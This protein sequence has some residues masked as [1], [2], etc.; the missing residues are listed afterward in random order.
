MTDSL[1]EDTKYIK[2]REK[3]RAWQF[4]FEVEPIK[5]TAWFPDKKH[6]SKADSLKAAQN[7]RDEFLRA[8]DT[9]GMLTDRK[10]VAGTEVRIILTLSPRNTS[11][12][13]G[14]CRI[15][16]K[17]QK[18]QRLEE[19]WAASYR[20]ESGKQ[21]QK[22]FYINTFGERA[23]MLSAIKFRRDYVASIANTF[24]IEEKRQ[25]VEKHVDDLTFLC[26]YIDS[27]VDESEFYT[28][29]STLNSPALLATEKQTLID[30][31]IGQARFRKIVLA[32][33]RG[34][35]CLT[36]ATNFLAAGHIKPWALA[37]DQERLDPYNGLALSPNLDKAFDTG[38]ITFSDEGLIIPS[39]ALGL[40]LFRLGF[41]AASRITGLDPRHMPYL[42]FHRENRFKP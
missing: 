4:Q 33:W 32:L 13:I 34:R 28:F 18:T 36:G 6:G 22:H 1:I 10:T 16:S 40:D 19:T 27:V 8:A 11:G 23:A 25:N 38:F 30:T 7:H 26:D 42:R 24:I 14:V 21:D 37:S 39:K 35:C 5:E 29:L 17:R 15:S 31:R 41:T 12:I 3:E 2:R 20:A 9:L